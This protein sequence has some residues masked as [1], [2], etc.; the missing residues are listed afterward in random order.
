MIRFGKALARASVTSLVLALLV[1][2]APAA[3]IA[4]RAPLASR[5]TLAPASTLSPQQAPS[6]RERLWS[7]GCLAW[8]SRTTPPSC[9]FGV[10]SS[11][12]TLALVGDSHVSHLFA[13]FEA[14]AKKRGWRLEVFVKVSCPFLD[15]RIRNYLED[16]EY[17]ECATWNKRVLKRLQEI[18][19]DLTVTIAFRGIHPMDASRNTPYREGAA[20]GRMLAKVPGRKAVIVDTPLS[21]RDVPKCLR[22]NPSNPDTCRIPSTEVLSS[23]VRTREKAAADVGNATY[24]DLTKSICGP[25]PCRV[26]K[27]GVVMFRDTHHLTNTYAATLRDVLG[28][29]LDRALD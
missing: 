26:V 9:V 29:A 27:N 24:L 15:I 18:R 19:P 4:P 21:Y 1:G 28:S 12:F 23:G 8:E 14:L 11:G 5:A 3:A 2:S 13:G 16:R 25:F 10:K 20:I 22:R 6:D 7:N 17:T